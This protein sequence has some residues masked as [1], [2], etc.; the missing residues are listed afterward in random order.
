MPVYNYRV[1]IGGESIAFSQVSG[2]N[3]SYETHVYKE[4][5]VEPGK[6][7]PVVMRMPAQQSDVKITLK[8]GVVKGKSLPKLYGWI[9]TM[10]TNQIEKKDITVAL[11]DETGT[12]VI[13]WHVLNAFPT[14]L[15]APSFDAKSNDAA[16]ESMELM[17]D[18]IQISEP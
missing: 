1:D 2:L 7:G 8:K 14:K 11:L 12:P 6:A 15:E 16:I 3:V 9:S 17:A 13:T 10:K 5:H 18:T 4:S